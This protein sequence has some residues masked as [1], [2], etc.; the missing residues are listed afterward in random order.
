MREGCVLL[1][2]LSWLL[3]SVGELIN[4]FGY[5]VDEGGGGTLGASS[6]SR[7]ALAQGP[8]HVSTS[9]FL[10]QPASLGPRWE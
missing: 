5:R 8:P 9:L 1:L 7:A 4:G 3:S 10:Q 6:I 2:L